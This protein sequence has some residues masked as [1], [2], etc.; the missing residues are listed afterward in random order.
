MSNNKQ[1][2]TTEDTVPQ[3]LSEYPSRQLEVLEMEAVREFNARIAEHGRGKNW[4][5]DHPRGHIFKAVDEL[6]LARGQEEVG[7]T[8]GMIEHKANA[9]NHILMGMEVVQTNP[10]Y[11]LPDKLQATPTMSTAETDP[12]HYKELCRAMKPGLLLTVNEPD[13]MA[14]PYDEMEVIGVDEDSGEV[15]LKAGPDTIYRIRHDGPDGE[16]IIEEVNDDGCGSRSN[17]VTT[18]EVIGIA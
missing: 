9:L 4:L 17:T 15:S 5:F 1:P 12:E 3:E 14:T 10:E 18:I 11:D 13:P 2:A 6:F 8:A 7:D 16:T